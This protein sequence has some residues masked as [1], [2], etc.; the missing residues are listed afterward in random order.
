MSLADDIKAS[1][2]QLFKNVVSTDLQIVRPAADT[3]L[4]GVVTAL[5][6]PATQNTAQAI[7]TLATASVAFEEQ[8]VAVLL[9]Q[10]VAADASDAAQSLKAL[11]DLEADNL[12]NQ[13]SGTTA[14][15]A[16]VAVAAT[17]TAPSA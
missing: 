3:Y 9:P 11:I 4:T 6:N 13:L 16:A 14:S 7:G 8:A 12:T 5:S 1:L 10:M 17:T 15:T 2:D